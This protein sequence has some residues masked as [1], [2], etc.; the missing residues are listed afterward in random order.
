MHN[1]TLHRLVIG[2]VTTAFAFASLLNHAATCKAQLA[3]PVT[4][5]VALDQIKSAIEQGI[6]QAEAAGNH[7]AIT[8]GIQALLAVT[9]LRN[10]LS[11][12]LDQA[13]DKVD[14]TVRSGI[15]EAATVAGKTVK[16]LEQ[17]AKELESAVAP[18]AAGLPQRIFVSD[19]QPKTY[20]NS[21]EGQ[22]VLHVFG[23]FPNECLAR[24]QVGDVAVEGKRQT[25][26]KL[27]F[28]LTPGSLIA[29]Q[30]P[31]TG[32]A[33]CTLVA[34]TV[35]KPNEATYTIAFVQLP[36]VPGRIVLFRSDPQEITLTRHWRS[37]PIHQSGNDVPSTWKIYP[38]EAFNG[39][40]WKLTPESVCLEVHGHTGDGKGDEV[41]WRIPTQQAEAGMG[42]VEIFTDAGGPLFDNAGEIDFSFGY[43]LKKNVKKNSWRREELDLAWNQGRS[44][45]GLTS[46]QWHACS[47]GFDGLT[48][49]FSGS[50]NV[51]NWLEVIHEGGSLTL[52]TRIP[53][54]IPRPLSP[55]PIPAPPEGDLAQQL[56]A[57]N[58]PNDIAGVYTNNAN[59]SL[60][61]LVVPDATTRGQRLALLNEAS[62]TTA[63]GIL[64]KTQDSDVPWIIEA[65]W[66]AGFAE[67]SRIHW[68]ASYWE[69]TGP[70]LDGV[71]WKNNSDPAQSCSVRLEIRGDT[72]FAIVTNEGG[73]VSEG[74]VIGGKIHTWGGGEFEAKGK[75]IRWPGSTWTR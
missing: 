38:G 1:C 45:V 26:K 60:R 62:A 23:S 75:V 4:V 27:V 72:V 36:Q 34:G 73:N 6:K 17:I 63:P 13:L 48:A 52:R 10:A 28:E 74:Q 66:G 16:D 65:S 15:A 71:D 31:K 22:I 37:N 25:N 42:T 14:K 11:D 54:I 46:G 40:G 18:L 64:A 58:W 70:P 67:G 53:E 3:D 20:V 8:A 7:V 55:T 61:C 29:I 50:S 21:G 39:R 44:F 69:R 32:V 68:P 41:D 5:G 30:D 33:S 19:Y 35:R 56:E 57:T 59:P 2:S 47:A 24:I 43:V 12:S 51:P 49:T 9:S